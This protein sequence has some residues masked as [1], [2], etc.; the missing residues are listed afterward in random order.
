MWFMSE[1]E[2]KIEHKALN[3]IDSTSVI[4]FAYDISM[5]FLCKSVPKTGKGSLAY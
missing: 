5:I 1:A 3:I 2:E 4:F